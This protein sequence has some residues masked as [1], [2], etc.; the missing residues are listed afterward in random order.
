M[1]LATSALRILD[2][3]IENRPLSYLGQDFTTGEVTSIAWKW[4]G[5]RSPY[6]AVL[7]GIDPLEEMLERFRLAYNAA[8]MVTGHYIR[9]HD[10]PVLNGALL[11]WG[12]EPLEQKLSQ[13]TK[14]DLRKQRYQS[15]SQENL[16]EMLGIPA[17]K[18][19]MNTPRWRKANRLTPDGIELTR[20]RAVGDVKQHIAL[21][22]KLLEMD[23]LGA[24]R[25]WRP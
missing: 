20:R 10:L 17:P 16:A 23:W 9:K 24:P 19:H 2:F 22:R 6:H 15:A 14:L 21:R 3:D 12:H 4:I 18:I 13:D 11:E 8:D 1:R 5:D 25:V 7:L